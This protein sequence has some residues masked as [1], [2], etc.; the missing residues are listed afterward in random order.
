MRPHSRRSRLIPESIAGELI[1]FRSSKH[2]L[3]EKKTQSDCLSALTLSLG[4][5]IQFRQIIQNSRA[6]IDFMREHNGNPVERYFFSDESHQANA[7]VR[8][9]SIV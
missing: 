4:N 6:R 7:Y 1:Y 5:L 9:T 8:M 2:F 3:R